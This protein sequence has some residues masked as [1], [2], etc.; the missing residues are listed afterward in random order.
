MLS[1]FRR[2]ARGGTAYGRAAAAA[3]AAVTAGAITL[4]AA[5]ASASVTRPSMPGPRLAAATHLAHRA[6]LPTLTVAMN[7]KSVKVGGALQ[8]GG[9]QVVSTVTGEPS[10]AALLVHLDRGVTLAQFLKLLHSP[11]AAD[12][13]NL[14]GVASVEVDAMA[15]HGSSWVQA[16]LP[17]GQY[18][19]F[20]AAASNPA[21]WPM[22]TFRLAKAA[23]PATLPAPDAT[24][25]SIEFGFRGPGTLHTGDLVRFAN[26]GF[27]FH[28]IVAAQGAT[29][30]KAQEL[31]R[32]LKEGKDAQAQKLAVGFATF[33]EGLSHG[34]YQQL[35]LSAKPGYWVLAC[36]MD[37]QDHREHTQLGME[38]V[39]HITK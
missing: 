10:G 35:T 30:A 32:L 18:V 14:I 28:M 8:S 11:K 12:P 27:L 9:L 37:T 36:F 20:D 25:A 3:A 6:P 5:A 26:H 22:T 15:P 7:G 33:D 31:A 19:A 38:R 2:L 1:C 39:I 13:N 24:V 23:H 4:S 16:D 21:Q 34:A 29:K 17:A